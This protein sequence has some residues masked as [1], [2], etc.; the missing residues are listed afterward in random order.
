[1]LTTTSSKPSKTL[2]QRLTIQ[3]PPDAAQISTVVDALRAGSLAI[4]PTETVYGLAADPDSCAAA[5]AQLAA[6]KGSDA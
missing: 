5:V 6:V 3:D 1:M 2:V 4:L